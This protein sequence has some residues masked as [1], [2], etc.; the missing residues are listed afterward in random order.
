MGARPASI[1]SLEEEWGFLQIPN[2]KSTHVE[3]NSRCLTQK[4]RVSKVE[5]LAR[6]YFSIT[7]K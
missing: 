7:E 3:R 2:L 1:S 4:R 5:A 6:I